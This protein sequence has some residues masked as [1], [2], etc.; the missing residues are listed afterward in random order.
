VG[1][2]VVIEFTTDLKYRN[3]KS[4]YAAFN[5]FIELMFC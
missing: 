3:K 1:K 2:G 4:F 5:N